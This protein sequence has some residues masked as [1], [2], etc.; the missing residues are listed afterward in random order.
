MFGVGD[1][2]VYLFSIFILYIKIRFVI[3]IKLIIKFGFC[4][5]DIFGGEIKN[6]I[7]FC[8]KWLIF[9]YYIEI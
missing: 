7:L 1:C 3:K 9:D 5:F 8:L 6:I 2:N 4:F